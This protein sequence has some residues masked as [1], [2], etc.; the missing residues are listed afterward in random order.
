MKT[1]RYATIILTILFLTSCNAPVTEVKT[2]FVGETLAT[3]CP[4]KGYIGP[5]PDTCLKVRYSKDSEWQGFSDPIQDFNYEE[6]YTHELLVRITYD[7][8]GLMDVPPTYT[9]NRLVR[10]EKVA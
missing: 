1:W 5:K 9:F 4:P 8:S 2:F 10:K 6:G 7:N 3:D